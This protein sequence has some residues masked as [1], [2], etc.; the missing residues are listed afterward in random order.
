MI[1]QKSRACDAP[2]QVSLEDLDHADHFY[3]HLEKVLD[4]SLQ[5]VSKND[6]NN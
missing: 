4:L 5:S 1:G 6:G 3:R 2:I